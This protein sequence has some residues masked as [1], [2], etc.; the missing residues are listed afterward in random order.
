MTATGGNDDHVKLMGK[1]D[2]FNATL[3]PHEIEAEMLCGENLVFVVNFST[4]KQDFNLRM[5]KNGSST[6]I[7]N[8]L[9]F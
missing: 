7:K 2:V 8:T 4:Y 1:N 5:L 6:L 9:Q 3:K